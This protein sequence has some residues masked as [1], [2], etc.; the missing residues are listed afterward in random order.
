MMLPPIA[1]PT[2]NLSH[3]DSSDLNELNSRIVRLSHS[4]SVWHGWYLGLIVATILLSIAL[5]FA[6]YF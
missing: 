6:Q 5:F 2:A 4:E 1:N 3:N